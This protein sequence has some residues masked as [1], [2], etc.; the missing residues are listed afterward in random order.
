MMRRRE[1]IALLGGAAAAWPLAARA[2]QGERMRRI[3]VLM[4]QTADDPEGQ[5]R[6]AAF[7]QELA[8]IGLDRRPQRAD[9]RPLVRRQMLS[10][11]ANARWNWWRLRRTSSWP[12]ATAAVGPLVQATRTVP[13]VFA[14]VADPV[15]AGIR[16]QP[17]AP[18]RKC[19]RLFNVRIRR[20]SEMAGVAQGD[21]AG[22]D[23]SGGLARPGRIRR[24]RPVRCD[25]GGGAVVRHG[26]NPGQRT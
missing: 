2:Q 24:A 5:A 15:G 12:V 19:H 6:I 1:F 16:R 9:R 7:L 3:G 20:R 8:A 25:P 14:V 13:I 21:Q 17:G 10:S 18:G 4:P 22:R 23:A 11:F 26:S